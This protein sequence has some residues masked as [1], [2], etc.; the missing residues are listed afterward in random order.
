M[1]GVACVN[2]PV[3]L[4]VGLSVNHRLQS[5][6]HS[7]SINRVLPDSLEHLQTCLRVGLE[8]FLVVCIHRPTHYVS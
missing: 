5:Y 6:R 8:Y 4:F 7:L 3:C 2:L 1:R